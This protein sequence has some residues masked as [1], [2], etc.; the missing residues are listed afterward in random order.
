MGFFYAFLHERLKTI[1][2]WLE[3]KRFWIIGISIHDQCCQIPGQLNPIHDYTTEGSERRLHPR[4]A[5]EEMSLRMEWNGRGR[6][7]TASVVDVSYRGLAFRARTNEK[8]PTRWKAEILQKNDPER[9]PIRLRALNTA[10]MPG[11]GV[12]VGCAY[13]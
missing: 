4:F 1:C 6:V 12:R 7:V 5:P 3:Y 8:W 13:V 11:G 10:P 9:H 2:R